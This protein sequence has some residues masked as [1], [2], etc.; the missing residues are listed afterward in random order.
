MFI[1]EAEITVA[2]GDGGNG[3]V[4]FR[5]E[6]FVPRGGPSG[7]DGGRGGSVYLEANPNDNT[8]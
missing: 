1:D 5:R 7:G 6:K 2:S 4:A 8:L 3:C